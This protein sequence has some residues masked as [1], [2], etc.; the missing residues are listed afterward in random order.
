MFHLIFS[1]PSWYVIARFVLPLAM[2]LVLK[3][4][5]SLLV[6]LASQYLLIS[7][8]T[9]GGI[10][11]PEM[12]RTVIILF[13]WAFSAVLFLA[14]T[15]L[16]IDAVT[17][18]SLLFRHPLEIAPGVRYLAALFAIA[19]GAISVHQ[20]IR[21]PPVKDVTIEIE[22]LP[23]EF[24]GYQL[25]QLTDLHITK[26]FNATWTAALVKRA[27]SLNANL[28][29]VTGDVIDG[30]LQNRRADVE[31]LRGLNAPDGVFAIT[32][33]H[34]YFF[35]Q[36]RW[37]DHLAS[38]GLHPLLNSHAI[39]KRDGAELVIAGLP[40]ASASRRNTIG[41]DLTK[42]LRGAPENA[43][44][45]LLDHQPRNARQNALQK[46]DLQLSGHTHGGLIVGFDRLFAKPNAGFVSGL[47]NVDGMQLYVNNGTAL[48]PGVAVRLGRPSELT[49]ITLQRRK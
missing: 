17:V 41:P 19:L 37:T 9:A 8:F 2:P 30:T 29:V 15:Q 6:L 3:V 18:M 32:G 25:L 16:L 24:E 47:Y 12:P 10:F 31:P 23:A 4:I 46:V 34:E 38:L 14:M 35:E 42:A 44:V 20:A 40:D 49:R 22:N 26:L 33:N 13:N 21:V 1:I 11:S 39:I 36:E 28:I 5:L 48:W 45:I 43:P 27:M 7:R